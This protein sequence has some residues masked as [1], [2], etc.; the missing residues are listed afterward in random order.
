M[1]AVGVLASA[2][3]VLL[4]VAGWGARYIGRGMR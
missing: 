3:A 1:I 2:W 4:A